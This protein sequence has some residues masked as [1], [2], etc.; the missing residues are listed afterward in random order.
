MNQFFGN[1]AVALLHLA[2]ASSAKAG[3]ERSFVGLSKGID[4]VERRRFA[5]SPAQGSDLQ[6]RRANSV[7]ILGGGTG[8]AGGTGVEG[9]ELVFP[10]VVLSCPNAGEAHPVVSYACDR[11]NRTLVETAV[12]GATTLPNNTS[13]GQQMAQKPD[14]PGERAGYPLLCSEA[15]DL[16]S[17]HALPP[18]PSSHQPNATHGGRPER[19]AQGMAAG[20]AQSLT[21]GPAA[22]RISRRSRPRPRS[23][24]HCPATRWHRRPG[25]H[26]S[27]RPHSAAPGCARSCC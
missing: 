10:D 4:P 7:I 5:P 12:V 22:G 2:F 11:L 13:Q 19:G 24:R 9:D 16:N 20:R 25:S 18:L 15:T 17:R 14:D 26:R 21:S 6:P 27:G 8:F 23:R 1:A 3:S